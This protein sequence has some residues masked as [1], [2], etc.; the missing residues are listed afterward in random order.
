MFRRVV[1]QRGLRNSLR[2]GVWGGSLALGLTAF[3]G[4]LAFAQAADIQS[5]RAPAAKVCLS[6]SEASCARTLAEALDR[7]A[8]G[9]EIL[10]HPGIYD[11]A[12]IHKSVTLHGLKGEEA[13]S[14][15]PGLACMRIEAQGSPIAVTMTG[16]NIGAAHLR[17]CIISNGAALAINEADIDSGARLGH[18]IEIESGTLTLG[19]HKSDGYAVRLFGVGQV[20]VGLMIA[21]GARAEVYNVSISRFGIAIDVQG[22]LTAADS[23]FNFNNTGIRVK[24]LGPNAGGSAGLVKLSDLLFDTNRIGV[25]VERGSRATVEVAGGDFFGHAVGIDSAAPIKISRVHLAENQVAIQLAG[26]SIRSRGL[27]VKPAYELASL[28]FDSNTGSDL[29]IASALSGGFSLHAATWSPALTNNVTI[30]AN[31]NLGDCRIDDTDLRTKNSPSGSS[32]GLRKLQAACAS[33]VGLT[34]SLAGQVK[35]SS[36]S[37]Q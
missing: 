13:P 26:Q 11:T 34:S 25:L 4:A 22:E 24:S 14:I 3:C 15:E 31:A 9:G 29:H 16:V 7:V 18:A 36:S 28:K 20:G 21:P 32:S 23:E 37:Q 10:V 27:N 30:A 35:G 8:S 6:A 33:G 19:A 12:D 17:G 5:A 1:S 2:D